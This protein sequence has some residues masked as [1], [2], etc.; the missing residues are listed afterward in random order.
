[1]FLSF[2]ASFLKFIRMY[3]CFSTRK[4]SVQRYLSSSAGVM[5]YAAATLFFICTVSPSV[6]ADA[7]EAS[8]NLKA[9]DFLQQKFLQN[10]LYSVEETIENDGFVNSY[11]VNSGVGT[12]HVNSNIALYKLLGE[13][14]AIDAMKRVE[15]SDAFL[16]SLKESGVNTVE[17]LKKLFTAP[18]TTLENAA[19][20]LSSPI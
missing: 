10:A 9:S 6:A 14:E 11:T 7:H 2:S 15:E 18:S 16:T 20:G 4:Y 12:F 19:S 3:S 1:M 17:G 5:N 8:L 13:L